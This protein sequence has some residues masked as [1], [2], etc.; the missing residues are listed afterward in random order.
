LL[1]MAGGQL[2]DAQSVGSSG[3]AMDLSVNKSFTGCLVMPSTRASM[4]EGWVPLVIGRV[5]VGEM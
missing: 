5:F 3:R 1:A 2:G 4:V